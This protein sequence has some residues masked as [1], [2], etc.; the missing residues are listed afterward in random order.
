MDTN[1][2]TRLSSKKRTR[3]DF[4]AALEL[5]IHVGNRKVFFKAITMHSGAEEGEMKVVRLVKISRPNIYQTK[6]NSQA[7]A[8]GGRCL[9]D[10]G[11]FVDF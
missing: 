5:K 6:G 9:S 11:T 4:G 1:Y 8:R 7:T 3:R 2:R 10:M